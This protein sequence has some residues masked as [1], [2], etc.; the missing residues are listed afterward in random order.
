MP[1]LPAKRRKKIIIEVSLSV[2]NKIKKAIGKNQEERF[3]AY[4]SKQ[5]ESFDE[6]PNQ[7]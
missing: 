6:E 7:S 3:N 4:I 2:K 5:I 1:D